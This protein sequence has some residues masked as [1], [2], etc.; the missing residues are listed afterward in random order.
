MT[1]ITITIN[2]IEAELK[3]IQDAVIVDPAIVRKLHDWLGS[4]GRSIFRIWESEYGTVTPI[5]MEDKYPHAVHF[6]EGMQ[7]RNF[8]IGLDEC[9]FWNYDQFENEYPVYIK[10]AM[11]DQPDPPLDRGCVRKLFDY[12]KKVIS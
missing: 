12:I 3:A 2:E 11:I 7:V 10:L 8:L 1:T 6:R 5:I 9:K 4:E